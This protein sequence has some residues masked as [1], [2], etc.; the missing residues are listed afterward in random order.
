LATSGDSINQGRRNSNGIAHLTH[1]Q[2]EILRL[3]AQGLCAKQIARYLGISTRTVEDHF[4]AM[5]RRTGSHDKSE[6]IAHAVAAGIVTPGA[7]PVG[8]Q[9]RYDAECQ[10]GV[11]GAWA[12]KTSC[13]LNQQGGAGAPDVPSGYA[14]ALALGR[15]LVQGVRFTNPALQVELTT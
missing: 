10:I 1:K 15:L 9:L 13:N 11:R 12:N 3:A 6:L 7:D 14:K 5:R 4:A 2:V 8:S